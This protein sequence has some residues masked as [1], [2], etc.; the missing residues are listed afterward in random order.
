MDNYIKKIEENKE[1]IDEEWKEFYRKLGKENTKVIYE[2]KS[3]EIV[4]SFYKN[5]KIEVPK[6]IKK[7]FLL[8]EKKIQ[9]DD[10]ELYEIQELEKILHD[11]VINIH[12]KNS[13]FPLGRDE[14]GNIVMVDIFNNNQIVLW[15]INNGI[16]EII[17][18][19]FEKFLISDLS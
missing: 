10:F 3:Y 17:A 9:I 5:L 8:N 11:F 16:E 18:D 14:D 12:W 19:S 6:I 13:L 2:K 15:N 1:L 7:F 4:N